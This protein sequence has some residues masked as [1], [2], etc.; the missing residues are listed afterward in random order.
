MHCAGQERCV[1]PEA[2]WRKSMKQRQRI[3]KDQNDQGF[4]NGDEEHPQRILFSG[5]LFANYTSF[6]KKGSMC[7]YIDMHTVCYTISYIVHVYGKEKYVFYIYLSIYLSV[8]LS[9]YLLSYC[10]STAE[11][12]T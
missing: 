3:S 10:I 1:T 9:I 5:R 7:V 8:Y 6:P 12:E 2:S 4:A 11:P